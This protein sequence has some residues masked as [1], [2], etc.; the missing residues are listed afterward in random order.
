LVRADGSIAALLGP[1]EEGILRGRVGGRS[2]L[3]P[4]TR[5]PWVVPAFSV[6]VALAALIARRL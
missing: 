4:F 3:S 2:D 6:L 1:G 5:A